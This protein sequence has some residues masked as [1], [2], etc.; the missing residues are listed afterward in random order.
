M[1]A[2]KVRTEQARNIQATRSLR[3]VKTVTKQNP[4][5]CGN[6]VCNSPAGQNFPE[7]SIVRTA[8]NSVTLD[9][10]VGTRHSVVRPDRPRSRG[11]ASV[12]A[13]PSAY[14]ASGLSVESGEWIEVSPQEANQRVAREV[15][16]SKL[17]EFRKYN[18]A[19]KIVRPGLRQTG[20]GHNTRLSQVAPLPMNSQ[21]ASSATAV[22]SYVY[23]RGFFKI[24]AVLLVLF[25]VFTVGI[26]GVGVVNGSLFAQS[27][28]TVS[29]GNAISH[30][31]NVSSVFLN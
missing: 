6:A 11:A 27:A 8:P 9:R 22:D 5:G 30:V 24:L 25:A 4:V 20:A 19:R 10:P 18:V 13:V 23:G 17:Y 26:L 29:E 12:Y 21:I 2:I 7:L 15:T 28:H 16:E 3:A 31:L 1:S 14:S